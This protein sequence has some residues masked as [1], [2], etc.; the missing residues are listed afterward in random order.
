[1]RSTSRNLYRNIHKK[2]VTFDVS[3]DPAD[4]GILL[5]FLHD[6]SERAEFKAQSDDYLAQAAR[7]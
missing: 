1:M 4:I 6:V 5:G 7:T 2:G 3:T